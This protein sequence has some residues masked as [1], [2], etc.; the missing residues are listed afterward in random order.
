MIIP[1]QLLIGGAVLSLVAGAAAGWTARDWKADADTLKSVE[2]AEKREADARQQGL[3]QGQAYAETS[4]T[5][6][7]DRASDRTVIERIYQNAPAP[8]ADC[9]APAP[10]VRVLENSVDRANAAA[11]GEPLP[12]LPA[13]PQTAGPPD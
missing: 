11:A 4:A 9:A 5:L 12:D 2:K 1:P 7:A 10:V 6:S 8:S 13:A 3:E